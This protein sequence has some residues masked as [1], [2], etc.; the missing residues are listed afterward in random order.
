[1]SRDPE[2]AAAGEPTAPRIWVWYPASADPVHG[3]RRV[4]YVPAALLKLA[5]DVVEAARS[6]ENRQAVLDAIAAYDAAMKPA[7]VSGVVD[8]LFTDDPMDRA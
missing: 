6:G 3:A 7:V 1:M 4:D 5:D 8:A 2:L